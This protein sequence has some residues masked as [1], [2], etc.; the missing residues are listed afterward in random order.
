VEGKPGVGVPVTYQ[1]DSAARFIH[2]RCIGAVVLEEVREHFATLSGDPE[3]PD[4]L[5][6][7]LDLSEMTTIPDA[8]ELRTVTTDIARIRPQVQFGSCAII[9][10]RD[11]LFGMARM[12][13]VFAEAYFVATRVFRAEVDGLAWLE[14]RRRGPS[15]ERAADRHRPG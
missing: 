11:A 6:V 13:E 3:C 1:I 2:T 5:D 9:A 8:S 10:S 15:A 4:R 7:L 14:S 12:F